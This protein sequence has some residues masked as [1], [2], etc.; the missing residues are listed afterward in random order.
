MPMMKRGVSGN[1]LDELERNLAEAFA[2][3]ESMGVS[4]NVRCSCLSFT[5]NKTWLCH[6]HSQIERRTSPKSKR[7]LRGANLDELEK[8]LA[9]AFAILDDMGISKKVVC[10]KLYALGCCLGKTWCFSDEAW[11]VKERRTERSKSGSTGE[12]PR[13][14]ICHPRH[15]GRFQQCNAYNKFLKFE[16]FLVNFTTCLRSNVGCPKEDLEEQVWIS[17][18]RT[19]LRHSPSLRQWAYQQM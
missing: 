6:L 9:E 7:G 12:E 2:I 11:H 5:W 1:N 8:N 4:S 17:S 18:R 13:W 3:L 10:T 15:H 16:V 14:G 19:W